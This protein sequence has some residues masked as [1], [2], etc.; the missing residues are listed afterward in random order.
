MLSSI[1]PYKGRLL[2]PGGSS[3]VLMPATTETSTASVPVEQP[4]KI[5]LAAQFSLLQAAHDTSDRRLVSRVLHSLP[6][7]RKSLDASTIS[8][9]EVFSN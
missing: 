3:S 4:G 8:S 6:K 7:V 9:L 2:H 5:D 1:S